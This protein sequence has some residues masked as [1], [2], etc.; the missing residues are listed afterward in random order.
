ML[1]LLCWVVLERDS[2]QQ[3]CAALHSGAQLCTLTRLIPALLPL[4][5]CPCL[6]L[7]LLLLPWMLR[8]CCCCC[9][10]LHASEEQLAYCLAYAR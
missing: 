2:R 10:A 9:A 5:C 8:S 3:Y 6:L 7:Q 4:L 1:L